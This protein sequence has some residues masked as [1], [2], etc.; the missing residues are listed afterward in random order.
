MI[1]TPSPGE[2]LQQIAD[3]LLIGPEYGQALA[4]Q[5]GIYSDVEL[6]TGNPIPYA[7]NL[8]VSWFGPITIPDSWL[9]P[10]AAGTPADTMPGNTKALIWAALGVAALSLF[11]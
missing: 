3:R 2:T 4:F 5:N 6:V 8:D 7:T 11:S 9:K 1:Y 10:G